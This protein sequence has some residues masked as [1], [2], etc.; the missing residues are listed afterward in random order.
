LDWRK[1]LTPGDVKA[2][3]AVLRSLGVSSEALTDHSVTPEHLFIQPEVVGVA[4]G[5]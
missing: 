3:I 5:S 1:T 2:S 4:F